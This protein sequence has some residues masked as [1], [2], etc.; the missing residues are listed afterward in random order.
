MMVE[1]IVDSYGTGGTPIPEPTDMRDPIACAWVCACGQYNPIHPIFV[2]NKC[3]RA[4]CN[5]F[6][7]EYRGRGAEIINKWHLSL[8]NGMLEPCFDRPRIRASQLS[9]WFLHAM[10]YE[11]QSRVFANGNYMS[12]RVAYAVRPVVHSGA[13]S[14]L[15]LTSEKE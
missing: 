10:E 12:P 4:G 15:R 1:G 14:A 3:Q 8:G 13:K 6:T 2:E 7:T 9:S 5:R 11:Q